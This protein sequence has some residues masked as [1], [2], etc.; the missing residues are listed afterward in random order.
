MTIILPS[1]GSDEP[2]D[3]SISLSTYNITFPYGGG[4]QTVT[5]ES[6][7][8]I[9]SAHSSAS[10]LVIERHDNMITLSATPNNQSGARAA[11]VEVMNGYGRFASIDVTQLGMNNSG[12][13]SGNNNSGS[14]SGNNNPGGNSGSNNP[15]SGN[16]Q[17]KPAAPT[18]VTVSNEGNSSVPDVRV[19][20]NSV[21]NAT[22][23]YVYKSTSASGSYSKIGESSYAQYGLSDPNPPTNGKSAYYKVKAVNSAGESAFSD[24][25]KYTAISNDEAFSPAYTYGNCTV[26]GSN[27]TLRWTYS[28]GS[29]YGKATE[30]ILRVWNP[31]AKEW[32]DTKLSATATSATFNF[33]T[34]IDDSGYVKAG[35]VVSNAKGSFTA[36]AKVY[37]SKNK[38]WI[39]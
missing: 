17:Q 3:T 9:S 37:D 13:N 23:Y 24:Y 19:R 12:G 34:K 2:E 4:T 25:A 28:T 39:N 29:G 7:G 36:G 26:S 1:C 35:I 18:G 38:K 22:T 14:N 10:W 30:A 8:Y 32:Q 6:N 21:S 27:I 33:S 20:W 16:T 15:G 31:Y 11:N 5:L